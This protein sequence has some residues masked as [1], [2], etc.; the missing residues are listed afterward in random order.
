MIQGVYYEAKKVLHNK[1]FWILVLIFLCINGYRISQLGMYDAAV[2]EGEKQLYQMLKGEV[3]DEK[4]DFVV[5]NY[6]RYQEIVEEGTYSREEN[7][8]QTY[9]GYI[10]GDYV[11]FLELFTEWKELYEYRYYCQ[12]I[13]ERAAE[14]VSFF[15][16]RGNTFE[17]VNNR[18]I[19]ECYADREIQ[20]FYHKDTVRRYLEYDFSSVFI[21]LL[22]LLVSSE[23]IFVENKAKMNYII[24]CSS[25][26]ETR[27]LKT[28][29]VFLMFITTMLALIF[30]G[31]DF[32]FF[33]LFYHIEG[34][35]EPLYSIME[36]KN[37]PVNWTIFGYQMVSI[38]IKI[39][40]FQF[41]AMLIFLF[42]CFFL[43]QIY[44]VIFGALSFG[45]MVLFCENT[46]WVWN[47]VLLLVNHNLFSDYHMVKLFN[48]PVSVITVSVAAVLVSIVLMIWIPLWMHRG[49][50]LSERLMKKG[51]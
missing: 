27:L 19:I 47:P 34:L 31:A 9:T 24:D 21:I 14:N 18:K 25:Y 5:S 7:T 45:S 23:L 40:G 32:I 48:R 36:Y 49:T 17:S 42:S 41:F 50:N 43:K 33:H 8:E 46:R 15:E 22:I 37:T 2:S 39:V 11:M 44:T 3:T 28:K 29:A 6:V 10:H 51:V 1:V 20:N 16:K 4:I 12:D 13:A 38:A 35:S 26:G 30:Y